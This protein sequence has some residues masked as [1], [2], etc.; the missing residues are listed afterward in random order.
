MYIPLRVLET[1]FPIATVPAVIFPEN[2]PVAPVMVPEKLPEVI[3]IVPAAEMFIVEFA[4]VTLPHHILPEA[5]TCHAEARSI[6]PADMANPDEV[7]EYPLVA[8][9]IPVDPNMTSPI[10]PV[11]PVILPEN[12]PLVIVIEPAAD[13]LIEARA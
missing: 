8:E 13:I 4:Y 12:V 7:R 10:V 9:V 1:S 11:A 5:S 2:V 3:V 6:E